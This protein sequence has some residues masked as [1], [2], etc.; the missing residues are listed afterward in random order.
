MSHFSRDLICPLNSFHCPH[1]FEILLKARQHH[2]CRA[3]YFQNDRT[4]EDK[5]PVGQC[6]FAIFENLRTWFLVFSGVDAIKTSNSFTENK[7]DMVRI[8]KDFS[9][10][11]HRLVGC[12]GPYLHPRESKVIPLFVLAL[13][14]SFEIST[15]YW[16]FDVIL[17]GSGHISNWELIDKIVVSLHVKPRLCV[18]YGAETK[19]DDE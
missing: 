5:T 11:C 7:R 9:H 17:D 13:C 14:M 12:D 4:A 15:K 19:K 2:G 1:R 6:L 18:I 16:H 8:L 3:M 10:I